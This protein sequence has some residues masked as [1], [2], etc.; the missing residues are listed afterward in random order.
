MAA[1]IEGRTPALQA[2]EALMLRPQRSEAER[3]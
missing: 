1:V 3:V 2:V